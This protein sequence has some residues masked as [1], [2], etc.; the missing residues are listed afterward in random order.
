M[1]LFELVQ[2]IV[3]ICCLGALLVGCFWCKKQLKKRV[4]V[5]TCPLDAQQP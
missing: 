5:K 1:E 2:T 4:S 3:T